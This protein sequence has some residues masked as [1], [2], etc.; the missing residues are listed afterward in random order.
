MSFMY[1]AETPE[2]VDAVGKIMHSGAKKTH[3]IHRPLVYFNYD[4]NILSRV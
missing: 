2:C 3:F 4:K 1:Y